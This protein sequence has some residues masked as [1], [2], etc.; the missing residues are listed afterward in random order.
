VNIRILADQALIQLEPRETTA[1]PGGL[2]VNPGFSYKSGRGTEAKDSRDPRAKSTGV[3]W[4]KVLSIGPGY[5][6]GCRKCGAERACFIPTTLRPGD[7]V[8]VSETS[9]HE[10]HFDVKGSRQVEQTTMVGE[11]LRVIREDEAMLLDLDSRQG[12]DCPDTVRDGA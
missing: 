8:L 7:R 1:L 3:R 12:E 4:A 5:Y 9:G 2:I 6:P 10:Y 11:D